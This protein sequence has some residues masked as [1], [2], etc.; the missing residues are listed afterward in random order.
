MSRIFF[1]LIPPFSFVHWTPSRTPCANDLPT[2]DVM[3]VR[4]KMPPT[5]MSP[6]ASACACAAAAMQR[7]SNAIRIECMSVLLS[8]SVRE[9]IQPEV[10]ADPPPPRREPVRFEDEEQHDGEA[11]DAELERREELD[12]RRERA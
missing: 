10:V 11:E 5:L 12:E 3:P 4:S 7:R 2:S 6:P 1:P 9:R 8:S